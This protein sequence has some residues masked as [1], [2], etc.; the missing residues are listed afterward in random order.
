[1]QSLANL[2][3]HVDEVRS[4]AFTRNGRWLASGS[5]DGTVR[6]WDVEKLKFEALLAP[7]DGRVYAVAFSPDDRRLAVGCGDWGYGVVKL[8][9]V[10]TRQLWTTLSGPAAFVHSVA[11]SPDGSRLAAGGGDWGIRIWK[12]PRDRSIP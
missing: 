6:L 3:G 10:E 12:L 4:L 11:F 1:M 2:T 8:W 9:N 7:Q 5:K